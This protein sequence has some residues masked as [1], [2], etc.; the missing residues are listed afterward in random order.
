VVFGP[1][2]LLALLAVA[3]LLSLIVPGPV[4]ATSLANSVDGEV[5]GGFS[6]KCKQGSTQPENVWTCPVF[7]SSTEAPVTYAIEV[8]SWGCWE[9]V[10]ISRGSRYPREVEGCVKLIDNVLG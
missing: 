10:R 8:H 4:G 2:A 3:Y 7:E 1:L 5:E 9:G 6:T